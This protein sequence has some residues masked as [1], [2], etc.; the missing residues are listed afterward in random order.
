MIWTTAEGVNIGDVNIVILEEGEAEISVMV[1][2]QEYRRQG[3]A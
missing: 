2:R 3:Y 1:A